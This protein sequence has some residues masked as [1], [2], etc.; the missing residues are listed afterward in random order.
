MTFTSEVTHHPGFAVNGTAE[1]L[2]L[3]M[4]SQDLGTLRHLLAQY[5]YTVSPELDKMAE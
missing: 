3:F 5:S 2:V 4:G 1:L